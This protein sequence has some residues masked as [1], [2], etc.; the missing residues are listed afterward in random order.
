MFNT[1]MAAEFVVNKVLSWSS[2]ED[3]F[4]LPS[5]NYWIGDLCYVLN[6]EL[7]DEIVLGGRDGVFKVSKDNAVPEF[8]A[9]AGTYAGDGNYLVKVNRK[10]S[11]VVSVDA[12]IIGIVHTSLVEHEE[13]QLGFNYSSENPIKVQMYD[14]IFRFTSGKDT[15]IINTRDY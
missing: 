10:K 4:E 6:E 14:G 12:G 13:K 11:G 7:Y 3:T 5:G 1:K 8:I 9:F 2:N 15:I